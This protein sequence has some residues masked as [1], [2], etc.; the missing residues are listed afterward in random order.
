MP[1]KVGQASCLPRQT[2]TFALISGL[3]HPPFDVRLQTFLGRLEAL[4]YLAV[5]SSNDHFNF[6]IPAHEVPSPEQC[7]H[8]RGLFRWRT[9]RV[10]VA[11]RPR[12]VASHLALWTL[13]PLHFPAQPPTLLGQE[14]YEPVF[15]STLAEHSAPGPDLSVARHDRHRTAAGIGRHCVFRQNQRLKRRRARGVIGRLHQ[16][17]GTVAPSQKLTVTR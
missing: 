11:N 1:F 13:S 5:T 2:R 15:R 9:A 4:P 3:S 16:P 17:P 8:C 6:I 14:P 10:E 7:L 12:L